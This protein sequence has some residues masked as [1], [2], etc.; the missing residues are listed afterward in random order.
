MIAAQRDGGE[1]G[2]SGHHPVDDAQAVWSTIDIV[3]DTDKRRWLARVALGVMRNNPLMHHLQQIVATMY[4]ANGVMYHL[5]TLH[6]L[7]FDP[8]VVK[9]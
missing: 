4:V 5:S 9:A 8:R 2:Q 6:G 1:A 3:T 7:G